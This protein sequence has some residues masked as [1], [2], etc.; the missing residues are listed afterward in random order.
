VV[1]HESREC[2]RPHDVGS[3]EAYDQ[4]VSV[5]AFDKDVEVIDG[6]A[7]VDQETLKAPIEANACFIDAAFT[8]DL[9]TLPNLANGRFG[10]SRNLRLE[11]LAQR[12]FRIVDFRDI[13]S[14]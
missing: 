6:P 9:Y 13:R 7:A 5:E 14:L 4:R 12:R 10:E 11:E 8:K 1:R 3:G 2:F